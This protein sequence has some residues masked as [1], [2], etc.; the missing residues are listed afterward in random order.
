MVVTIIA[1]PKNPETVK[2]TSIVL[3]RLILMIQPV[4]VLKISLGI[5]TERTIPK[6]GNARKDLEGGMF[7]FNCWVANRNVM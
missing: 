1:K 4:V 2:S 5:I 3:V 7:L 6:I